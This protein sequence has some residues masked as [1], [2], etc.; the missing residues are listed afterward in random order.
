MS[1]LGTFT[2]QARTMTSLRAPYQH[3]AYRVRDNGW[4]NARKSRRGIITRPSGNTLFRQAA[5]AVSQELA[6]VRMAVRSSQLNS[7]FRGLEQDG[8]L[9]IWNSPC[10]GHHVAKE[11][12]GRR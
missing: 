8:T 4:E 11:R 7:A 2:C 9:D 1:N 3:V 12:C 6:W 10:C 5:P